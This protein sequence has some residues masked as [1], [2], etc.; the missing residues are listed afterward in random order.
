MERQPFEWE[1]EDIQRLIDNQI[2]ES[3]N[4]DYKRCGALIEGEKHSK[5]KIINELSKDVSSFANAEG[6][7]IIYGI[8][9]EGSI[10]KEID[11][12]FDPTRIK[13]EF[14]EN[15]IDASIKPK[16]DGLRI[17]QIELK[18]RNPG[19]VIYVVYIPQSLQ[20]AIQAK[21]YRY[22]QRRNFK[23]EPMEDYQVRDVMNRF[24][25]PLLEP[26]I[27]FKAIRET[28]DLHEYELNLNLVNKGVVTAKAFG[29]DMLFPTLYSPKLEP[30]LLVSHTWSF[31][32]D[33]PFEK[34]YGIRFRNPES[35]AGFLFPGEK[36][37][38]FGGGVGLFSYKVND[39]NWEESFSW[40]IY[41]TT[42][43][44][45]MPPKKSEYPFNKFLHF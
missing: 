3:T 30:L 40:K 24:K 21:D 32:T 12:G 7:T 35:P 44:D 16:I 14:L 11:E 27:D 43:A 19:K 1:E 5:Q 37:I 39:K 8:I 10:P 17:K 45:D 9:E 29:M 33:K 28:G 15:I 22:Y 34:Y 2:Q 18:N 31:K 4:L 13:R 36:K 20:G 42:Y 26:E 38:I 6:G 41:I 23:A 25:Y